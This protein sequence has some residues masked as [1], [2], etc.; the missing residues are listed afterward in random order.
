MR[1]LWLVYCPHCG[2]AATNAHPPGTVDFSERVR[3]VL[4][5]RELDAKVGRTLLRPTVI[6]KS[7][8]FDLL[9]VK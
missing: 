9:S 2:K 8:P 1:H 3:C 7:K 6:A 5:N 4:C